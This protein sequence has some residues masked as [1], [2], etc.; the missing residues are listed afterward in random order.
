[1]LVLIVGS[2]L[3]RTSVDRWFNAPM[4]EMLSSANKIAS[5]YYA[6]RQ[7]LVDRP[8]DANRAGAVGRLISQTPT[9]GRSATARRPTYARSASR[10]CGVPRG[11]A[12]RIARRS[13]SRWSKLPR[14]RCRQ[15]SSGAAVDRLAS[16]ALHGTIDAIDRALATAAT[17]CAPPS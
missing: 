11:L 5:D 6:E 2:E 12:R 3:I 4:D 13:C 10:W 16:Q 8:C 1:V 17:C 15:G 9:S 7:T 14:Q